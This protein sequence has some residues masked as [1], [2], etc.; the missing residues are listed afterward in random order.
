MNYCVELRGYTS[1]GDPYPLFRIDEKGKRINKGVIRRCICML[2]I[3]VKTMITPFITYSS[4][5]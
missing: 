5:L 4:P 1:A 3:A 2:P